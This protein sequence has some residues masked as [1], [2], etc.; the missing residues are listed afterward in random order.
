MSIF[1]SRWKQS[2]NLSLTEDSFTVSHMDLGFLI[3]A[4]IPSSNSVSHYYSQPTSLFHLFIPI[5]LS[6]SNFVTFSQSG[7]GRITRWIF[8]LLGHCWIHSPWK[9]C[10]WCCSSWWNSSSLSMQWSLTVLVILVFYLFFFH[11]MGF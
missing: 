11:V 10:S 5:K 3:H 6:I 8:H 9:T 7:S 2:H 1:I 4:L